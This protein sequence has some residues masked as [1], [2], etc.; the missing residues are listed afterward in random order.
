MVEGLGYVVYAVH[1]SVGSGPNLVLTV[2]MLVLQQ[3]ALVCCNLSIYITSLRVPYR[4]CMHSAHGALMHMN[5]LP[6]REP[7][8]RIC[9]CARSHAHRLHMRATRAHASI[10]WPGVHAHWC[11]MRTQARTSIK[12]A[13]RASVSIACA[14]RTC[15]HIDRICPPRAH[16]H[17]HRLCAAGAYRYITCSGRE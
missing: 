5:S 12:F 11:R 14:R 15:T 2:L 16:T 1:V 3:L 4:L 17:I 10:C 9:V 8:T 6:V 13:R 7:A